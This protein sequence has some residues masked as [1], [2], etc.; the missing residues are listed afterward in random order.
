MQI[1]NLN[2]KPENKTP[3]GTKN[4]HKDKVPQC[5]HRHVSVMMSSHRD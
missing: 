5:Y 2:T 1:I 4:K 3:S